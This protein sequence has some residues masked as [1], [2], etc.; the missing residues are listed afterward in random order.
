MNEE[1]L[2]GL[3][4]A[5]ER[6]ESMKRAMMTFYNSGYK[7]EEIEE[8]AEF[9]SRAQSEVKKMPQEKTKEM[10]KPKQPQQMAVKQTPSKPKV[11]EYVGKTE[12]PM[13]KSVEMPKKPVQGE[14][15]KVSSYEEKKTKEKKAIPILLSALAFL[16][17][18]LILIFLFRKQLIDFFGTLLG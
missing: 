1:I 18:L 4:S 16:I 8:A 10:A 17:L 9:L 13:K 14:T 11:S 6:G 2:G 12:Q 5:L 3:K 7:K 15:Q